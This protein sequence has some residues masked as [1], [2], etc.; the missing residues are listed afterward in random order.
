[1]SHLPYPSD[2]TDA[3][4]RLIEPHLPP[5]QE[6]GCPRTTDLREVCN[7]IFYVM[8]EGC[9]CAALPHDYG[10]PYKT[11]YDYYRRWNTDGTLDTM[12][13]ALRDRVRKKVGK[14]PTPSAAII[15]SQSVKTTQRGGHGA[16]MP[17]NKST[18]GNA[19]SS[20]IRWACS[21]WSKF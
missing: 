13:A 7:A 6:I 8:R 4:W 21:G 19:L 1:M 17:A 2:L 12:H 9:R 3:Q 18:A 5:P 15:D 11:V 16:M 14:E 10:I 20:W